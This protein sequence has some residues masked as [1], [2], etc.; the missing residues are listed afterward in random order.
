MKLLK[1]I[2]RS[3]KLEDEMSSRMENLQT[4]PDDIGNLAGIS[5]DK[6]HQL[7]DGQMTTL[8]D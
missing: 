4:K 1:L 2:T 7:L 6:Q 5:L 3:L 8:K